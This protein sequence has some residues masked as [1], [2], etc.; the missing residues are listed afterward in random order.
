MS[1]PRLPHVPQLALSSHFLLTMLMQ[2]PGNGFVGRRRA[3]RRSGTPSKQSTGVE[4]ANVVRD[5]RMQASHELSRYGGRT[6]H[7]WRGQQGSGHPLSTWADLKHW[8]N[9]VAW[10]IGRKLG[11]HYFFEENGGEG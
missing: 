8:A 2:H 11:S 4:R 1:S 5:E 10:R 7:C 9:V 6:N 3:W